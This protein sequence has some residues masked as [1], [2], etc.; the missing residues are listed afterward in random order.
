[1]LSE[2]GGGDAPLWQTWH[3]DG[4]TFAEFHNFEATGNQYHRT[5]EP[6]W[7]KHEHNGRCAKVAIARMR[8]WGDA[9]GACELSNWLNNLKAS[10]AERDK[11]RKPNT[12]RTRPEHSSLRPLRPLR[13]FFQNRRTTNGLRRLATPGLNV[14]PFPGTCHRDRHGSPRQRTTTA[15]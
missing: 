14:A 11:Q 13:P 12:T 6:P 3:V 2:L 10:G 5:P 9:E 8:E 7:S 4:V 1:M 15:L